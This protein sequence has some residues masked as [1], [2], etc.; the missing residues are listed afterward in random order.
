MISNIKLILRWADNVWK[1]I[2][3]IYY[4]KQKYGFL[5]SPRIGDVTER[6]T[7]VAGDSVML[8]LDCVGLCYEILHIYGEAGNSMRF[9]FVIRAQPNPGD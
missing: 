8:T 6:K 2:R 1:T 4:S 7:N 9:P 3:V 5:S